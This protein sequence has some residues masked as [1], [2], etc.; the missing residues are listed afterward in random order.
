MA[1]HTRLASLAASQIPHAPQKDRDTDRANSSIDRL[2]LG[3]T[4]L[5]SQAP[6][7]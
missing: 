4:F 7:V 2:S 1:L 6:E 3:H 5:S